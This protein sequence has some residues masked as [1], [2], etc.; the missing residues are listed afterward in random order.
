MV[1]GNIFKSYCFDKDVDVE[2]FDNDEDMFDLEMFVFDEK[3][4]EVFK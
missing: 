3:F 4:I 1:I 2:F